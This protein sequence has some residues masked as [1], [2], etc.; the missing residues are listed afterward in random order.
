MFLIPSTTLT[1]KLNISLTGL[2]TEQLIDENETALASKLPMNVIKAVYRG[3]KCSL[4][5]SVIEVEQIQVLYVG[6]QIEDEVDYP[7]T[8]FG[9]PLQASLASIRTGG[10]SL[11]GSFGYK[12]WI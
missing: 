6:L 12:E 7:I 9:P 3:A 11:C 2:W 8:V 1:K 4:I 10:G 5:I